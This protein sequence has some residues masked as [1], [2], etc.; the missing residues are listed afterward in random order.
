MPGRPPWRRVAGWFLLAVI[1][2]AVSTAA[3]TA[4]HLRL[5]APTGTFPTGKITSLWT[6]PARPEPG[7][8]SSSDRRSVRVVAWYPAEPGTGAPAAYLADLETIGDGLV[9]SGEVGSLEMAGLRYVRDPAQSGADISGSQAAYP[10]V[11]LSPGNA[12]NVEFYSALAEELASHGFVVIGLDHPF[13]VAAV[14]LARE[15]AVYP[16]DPPLGQAAEVTPD[17]IDE[18]VADIAFVLDSLADQAPGLER[19]AG[20]IDLSRIGIM[21]H[22]NG[23]VAAAEACA[24]PRIDACLN[25]DGQLAGG[26]F[27]AGPDPVPPSK[28]FMYLTKE[29]TIHPSLAALFEAAGTDTFR[30]VVPAAAHDEFADPAMFRP[31]LLPTATAADDTITVS[32]GLT[33]AFFDHAL[34]DAPI[35]VFSGLAAP[36]NIQIFVYPLVPRS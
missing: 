9:A 13:Q 18:R 4:I 19:L 22:S 28:P 6:D 36:T 33:V 1:L 20:R 14:A 32:R 15:V 3:S 5:P 23:G 16:G 27:S 26:P 17:R 21:G 11:V 35:N 12:T 31:R 29:S 34:R 8:V 10:V 30:V 2:L 7:T 24:D 25:I